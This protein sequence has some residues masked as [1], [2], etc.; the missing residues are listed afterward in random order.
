[1]IS[2]CGFPEQSHFQV[3]GLLTRRMARNYHT[4]FVGEIYRGAGALLQDEDLK[5]FVDAHMDRNI[6]ANRKA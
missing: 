1:M 4:E 5:P 2:N 3:L 6:A